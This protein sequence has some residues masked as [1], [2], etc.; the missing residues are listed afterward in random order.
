MA[1][2]PGGSEGP[3]ALSEALLTGVLN[4]PPAQ[5]KASNGGSSETL[6]GTVYE[7]AA[8]LMAAALQ[9]AR[10]RDTAAAFAEVM[11]VALDLRR[12]WTA[13]ELADR[14]EVSVST[15]SKWRSEESAPRDIMRRSAL[16]EMCGR[17][18]EMFGE[19][20]GRGGPELFGAAPDLGDALRRAIIAKAHRRLHQPEAITSSVEF[21]LNLRLCRELRDFLGSATIARTTSVSESTLSRWSREDGPPARLAAR[22]ALVME[23]RSLIDQKLREAG[24]PVVHIKANG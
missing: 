19:Q 3:T 22:K 1:R 16:R 21:A 9:T 11:D 24:R 4:E 8:L 18:S 5:A 12:L 2:K 7:D 17:L 23:L 13:A 10:A 20:V 14:I 15:L 6:K